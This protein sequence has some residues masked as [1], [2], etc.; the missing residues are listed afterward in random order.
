M[1]LKKLSQY[2]KGHGME[3]SSGVTDIYFGHTHREMDGV[4]YHGLRYHNGGA[5]I[6]GI[7]F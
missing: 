7:G 4:E 1:V 2:L 5:S 6:K 3:A